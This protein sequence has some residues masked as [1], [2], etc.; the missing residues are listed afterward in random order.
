M[1]G[2]DNPIQSAYYC[3]YKETANL[4]RSKGGL[5]CLPL[6]GKLEKKQKKR[7]WEID[8]HP[9]RDTASPRSDQ[10]F[11]YYPN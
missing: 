5:T 4:Y 6:W 10:R 3:Q 7:C 9:A 1:E 8:K 11:Y 2:I